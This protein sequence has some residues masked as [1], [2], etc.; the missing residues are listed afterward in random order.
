MAFKKIIVDEKPSV[1]RKGKMPYIFP[2]E[3]WP[4]FSGIQDGFG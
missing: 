4:Y 1:H 3:M 2:I